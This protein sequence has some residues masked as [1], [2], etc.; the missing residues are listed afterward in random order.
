L[1]LTVAKQELCFQRGVAWTLRRAKET[2]SGWE[3]EI[4]PFVS[5]SGTKFKS[6]E[7]SQTTNLIRVGDSFNGIA[8]ENDMEPEGLFSK[9]PGIIPKGDGDRFRTAA[10]QLYSGPLTINLNM[11]TGDAGPNRTDNARPIDGHLTYVRDGE[12]DPDKYRAGVLSLGFGPIRI[13]RNS[14]GIRK[15]FQNQF[16]HDFLTGGK[17]KWFKVLPIEPSWYWYWGT[18]TGGTL[19]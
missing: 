7:F 18:D 5:Y 9:F 14:E 19:W 4:I 15:V 12:Y 11:F 8:Y 6:G 17:S 16:A 13:G 2:R 3:W 1:V 10:V